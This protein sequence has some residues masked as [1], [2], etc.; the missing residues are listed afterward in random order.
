MFLWR[1]N[2][3]FPTQN[4]RN[5]LFLIK[6]N[7]CPAQTIKLYVSI[8]HR[9]SSFMREKLPEAPRQ[10]LM[11]SRNVFMLPQ[12]FQD[13]IKTR[14]WLKHQ[15]IPSRTLFLTL[16]PTYHF[17]RFITHERFNFFI[18]IFIFIPV[19]PQSWNIKLPLNIQPSGELFFILISNIKTFIGSRVRTFPDY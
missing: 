11:I 6:S 10:I 17:S 19:D 13:A 15:E 1:F 2:E 4:D 8:G 9:L 14:L 7:K 5:K 12:K 3:T 18:F 16:Q